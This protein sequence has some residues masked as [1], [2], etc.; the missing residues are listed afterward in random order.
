MYERYIHHGKNVVVRS[1]L[2]GKHGEHCLCY[3]CGLLDI[4]N[5]REK[6]CPTANALFFF[7][8]LAGITTPVWECVNFKEA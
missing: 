6:N 4:H 5:D 8:K 2:K 3:S 7:N 1:D